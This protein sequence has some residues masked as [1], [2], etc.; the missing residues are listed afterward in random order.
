[1]KDEL[2][3]KYMPPSYYAYFLNRWHQFIQGNKSAKEF[4]AMFNKFLIRCSVLGTESEVQILFRFRDSLRE[5]LRMT[6]LARG[7][8]ELEKAYTLV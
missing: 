2:K 1:M 8:T 6:L 4:V 5:D 7:V 3:G